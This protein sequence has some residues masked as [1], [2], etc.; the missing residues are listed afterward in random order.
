[1]GQDEPSLEDLPPAVFMVEGLPAAPLDA[2]KTFHEDW[3]PEIRAACRTFE[4]VSVVF[5]PASF[6]H[7]GWRLA[8]IQNLA[9]ETAPARVNGIVGEVYSQAG[10]ASTIAWLCAAPGIT[11]QLLE[12]EPA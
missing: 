5:P 2:A 10:V 12:V 4:N 11:G 1:M 7:R 8:A 9:R 6:E 3:L